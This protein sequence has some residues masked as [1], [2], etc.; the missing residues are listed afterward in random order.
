MPSIVEFPLL[1]NV[2]RVISRH[3]NGVALT[4]ISRFVNK[5]TGGVMPAN[6]PLRRLATAGT[7]TFLKS[8]SEVFISDG[9]WK[10]GFQSRG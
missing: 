10:L 4:E 7:H 3:G 5:T 1:G 9:Y 2:E 6:S 8:E